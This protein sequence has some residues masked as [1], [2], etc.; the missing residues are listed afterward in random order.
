MLIPW[1][2]PGVGQCPGEEVLR[3]RVVAVVTTS[4][5]RH[6]WSHPAS[7]TFPL[8]SAAAGGLG[9][10]NGEGSENPWRDI[11]SLGPDVPPEKED[12]MAVAKA[13]KFRV[14]ARGGRNRKRY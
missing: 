11:R 14:Q 12:V 2:T 13:A 7:R 3:W 8:R 10:S 1:T 9:G 5:S 4:G 6:R